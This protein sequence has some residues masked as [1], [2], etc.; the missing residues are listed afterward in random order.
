MAE[1]AGPVRNWDADDILCLRACVMKPEHREWLPEILNRLQAADD[2]VC[3][4]RSWRIPL[5]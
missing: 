3:G 2:D 4:P 5:R 1:P